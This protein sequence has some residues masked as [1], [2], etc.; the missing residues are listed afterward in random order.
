MRYLAAL[1]MLF[2]PLTSCSMDFPWTNKEPQPLA[3]P[4]PVDDKPKR[5]AIGSTSVVGVKADGTVWSWGVG[6][7]GELGK[8]QAYMQEPIPKQISNMTDFIEVAA[9]A[10]HF[11]AL[12]EDGTVWSWGDNR[13]GQLGYETEPEMS[14]NPVMGFT[15]QNYS[16]KP[17]EIE[18]LNNIKSIA[19]GINFSVA[20]DRNGNIYSFGNNESGAL[21]LG[22]VDKPKFGTKSRNVK[23]IFI[24]NIPNAAKIYSSHIS[25]VVTYNKEAW[26]FGQIGSYLRQDYEVVSKPIKIKGLNHISSLGLSNNGIYFLMENGF[27]YASGIIAGK[28][29]LNQPEMLNKPTKINNLEPIILLSDKGEAG[30]DAN[31]KIWL[32]GGVASFY[33]V[34]IDSPTYPQQKIKL[35]NIVDFGNNFAFLSDGSVHFWGGYY[36]GI[37]GVNNIN[38]YKDSLKNIHGIDFERAKNPERSLWTWK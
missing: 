22:Y 31:G 15:G 21:G 7:H 25:A 23:P 16:I 9:G 33:K 8:G 20:L 34:F 24:G 13:Y 1:V 2:V 14:P 28:R 10:G 4:L 30:L 6:F 19:A 27:I 37:R 3:Q 29:Q 38:D 32:W 11:L 17:K 35:D 12:R 36:G 26:V 18:G 5:L